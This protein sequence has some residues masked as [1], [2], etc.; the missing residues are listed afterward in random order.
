M[1]F[2]RRNLPH[3]QPHGARYFITFRL[4]GSLPNHVLAELKQNQVDIQRALDSDELSD[5]ER[6]QLFIEQKKIFHSY[7]KYLDHNSNGPHWLNQKRIAQLVADA[8]HYRDQKV[9]DLIAYCIMSNH[10]HIVFKHHPDVHSESETPITDI[11]KSLKSYTGKRANIL[12][13]RKGA[14]WKPES[15]DRV[16]RN[17]QELGRIIRYTINNPVKAGLVANWKD[18]PYSYL[19]PKFS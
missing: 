14:F 12:L 15:Y 5:E 9:Y 16:I 18:W 4:A 2:Y 6:E 8:I 3:W 19:S 1:N 7:A 10:V 17:D 13:D 11:L